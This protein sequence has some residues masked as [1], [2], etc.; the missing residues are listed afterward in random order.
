MGVRYALLFTDICSKDIIIINVYD[1]LET[2]LVTS[3]KLIVLFYVD[4]SRFYCKQRPEEE[5]CFRYMFLQFIV[6]VK[7]VVFGLR[8]W[9]FLIIF[10][11]MYIDIL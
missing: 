6:F 5:S 7:L 2:A 1:R 10:I 4:F 8:V 9:H 11:I 3:N